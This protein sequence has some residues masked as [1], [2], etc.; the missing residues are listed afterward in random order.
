M[1]PTQRSTCKPTVK[2]TKPEKASL[3]R[4]G[5]SSAAFRAGEYVRDTGD[6]YVP[7][8]SSPAL[9]N[10]IVVIHPT[11]CLITG[12]LATGKEK[13]RWTEIV[14]LQRSTAS[15]AEGSVG[16]GKEE[17]A[18]REIPT[19]F[20]SLVSTRKA[21]SSMQVVTTIPPIPGPPTQATVVEMLPEDIMTPLVSLVGRVARSGKSIHHVCAELMR[22]H[23]TYLHSP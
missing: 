9:Y 20:F 7:N 23:H 4:R 21:G 2:P 18:G 16:P 12:R 5:S 15:A 3:P 22:F 8:R 6:K 14:H 10:K 13:E 19:P 17:A 11:K 1:A